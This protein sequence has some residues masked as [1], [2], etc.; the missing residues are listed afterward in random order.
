MEGVRGDAAARLRG[1]RVLLPGGESRG[2]ERRVPEEGGGDGRGAG[3]AAAVSDAGR[4]SL[5]DGGEVS[6]L[7]VQDE[8]A[9]DVRVPG[10]AE[11][12][13]AA[14]VLLRP[15]DRG[16]GQGR[17]GGAERVGGDSGDDPADAAAAGEDALP[18]EGGR[19]YAE[20]LARADE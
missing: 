2:G 13:A 6:E 19:R 10:E 5:G 12:R 11:R 3:A 15:E 1:E 14:A 16:E 4:A 7:P 17:G 9:G 18:E 8:D 20:E